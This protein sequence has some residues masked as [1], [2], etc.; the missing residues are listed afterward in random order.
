MTI[1]R[2]FL[3]A[4]A[5]TA[6]AAAVLVP[7]AGAAPAASSS[8]SIAGAL[9]AGST[10]ALIDAA[11]RRGDIDR[12][13][14]D[15]YL[16]YAVGRPA[17]LPAAYRSSVPWRGTLPLLD[18]QQRAEA[19]AVA[20]STARIAGLATERAGTDNCGSSRGSLPKKKITNHFLIR[21]DP[22]GLRALRIGAYARTLE[23]SWHTEITD[24]G[25]PAPPFK[26]GAGGLFHVRID[27]LGS[28]LYGYVTTN[29]TTAGLVG[30]NPNTSWPDHDAYASCMVLNRDYRG[31]PSPPLKSLQSTAAHEFNHGIQFGEG[32]LTGVDA[33]D[34][35]FV[36]GGATW[37]EDEVFDASNDNYF[38]LWPDLGT[39]MGEY[40]IFPYPYWVTFRAMTEPYGTGVAGGG[41]DVMQS[42]WEQTSREEA[43]NLAAMNGALQAEGTTLADAFHDAAITIRFSAQCGGGYVYPYC[44]EEGD[45]YRNI[46]GPY[47]NDGS[48]AS[49]GGSISRS[50]EDNYAASFIALP[51]TGGT[52]DVTLDNTSAGG[53]LRGSV[54]CDTDAALE[55]NAL[56]QVAGTGQSA[57]LT[58]FDPSGCSS[59]VLVVTNES[60]TSA[61]P[62]SSASRSFTVDTV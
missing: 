51:K 45:A 35:V 39:S 60:Q 33:P 5:G 9:P 29:G 47:G 31:F 40:P 59:V 37:M 15:R 3:V 58:N 28:S 17:R 38:Y 19:G 1:A 34:T 52:Y 61:N 14:A 53:Q 24:F 23:K 56:S 7:Q 43:G 54:V 50:V 16:A 22:S 62:G 32:A 57:T 12:A 55:V 27:R 46:A 30:N 41:E 49:I 48:I 10:P 44:F 25:W 36:E 21:Y 6:L 4:L 26:S 20:A 18:L 2:R 42:L 13:T 8:A 11:L